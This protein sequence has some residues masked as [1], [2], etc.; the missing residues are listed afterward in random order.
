MADLKISEK[1]YLAKILFTTQQL[2][3]VEVARRV[4]VS[5][6]TMNTWVDK[7][8]WRA[9][10]NRLLT[11]KQEILSDMYEEL[12]ELQTK[13]K[14]R[15]K[16][17]RHSNTKEADIKVK[18]TASIRALE[19]DLG[20]ADLVE[21]GKRFISFLQQTGTAEQVTDFADLWHGF[22]QASIKQ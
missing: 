8:N 14:A 15:E 10:R 17:E 18:L 13:I 9:M 20:I 22:L 19:T 16:G 1:Q 7:F 12:E 6:N 3:Q 5:K 4:G 11:G 21:S 2:D